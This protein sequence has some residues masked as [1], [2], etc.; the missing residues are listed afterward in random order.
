MNDFGVSTK[1]KVRVITILKLL[2]CGIVVLAISGNVLV[3]QQGNVSA[4]DKKSMDAVVAAHNSLGGQKIDNIK[5]L[6]LTGSQISGIFE[7]R[8]STSKMTRTGEIVCEF[9]IRVLFPDSFVQISRCPDWNKGTIAYFGI[10]NG[11]VF[12]IFT[13][14]QNV[15]NSSTTQ[16]TSD[17]ALDGWNRL[18][19]GMIMKGIGT[20]L[21]F[22]IDHHDNISIE[23]KDGLLGTMVFDVK[24]KWPVKIDYNVTTQ[25]PVLSKGSD[26]R[27]IYTGDSRTEERSAYV[28]FSDRFSVDGIIFPKTITRGDSDKV[29]LTMTINDIKINPNLSKEDFNFPEKFA[30]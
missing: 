25:T 9:E 22:S 12:N 15:V 21:V 11:K 28:Q 16:D 1:I 10:L 23:R 2:I 24:D 26:G 14:L 17:V 19:A 8:A 30:K 5:S 27:M 6:V 13:T 18:L 20:P 7:T 4:K 29:E 3:A